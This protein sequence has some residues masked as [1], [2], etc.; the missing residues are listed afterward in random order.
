MTVERP[1]VIQTEHLDESCAE[2]LAE[3]CLV[4]R[5]APEASGFS[6]LLR[7]ASESVN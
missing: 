6:A 2:W 7:D 3:R 4:E 1:L 5:C